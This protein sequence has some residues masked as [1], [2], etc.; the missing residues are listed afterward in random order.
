MTS[1]P[2]NEAREDY[3]SLAEE[4]SCE[5][6]HPWDDEHWDVRAVRNAKRYAKDHGLPWPPGLGDFDRWYEANYNR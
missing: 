4:A 1:E 2:Y 5:S 6:A 3:A